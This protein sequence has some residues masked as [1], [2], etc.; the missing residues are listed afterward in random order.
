MLSK[1][2]QFTPF[3]Q[4]LSSLFSPPAPLSI[5]SI[6]STQTANQNTSGSLS[7]EKIMQ[8]S[9][10]PTPNK[11]ASIFSPEP[12][13]NLTNVLNDRQFNGGVAAP[14]SSE[15]KRKVESSGGYYKRM[16]SPSFG[17][18]KDKLSTGYPDKNMVSFMK[19]IILSNFLYLLDANHIPFLV[20]QWLPHELST[21][22]LSSHTRMPRESAHLITGSGRQRAR[23]NAAN[24]SMPYHAYS[25][26]DL[27]M[28][29][30]STIGA[31]NDFMSPMLQKPSFN[32]KQEP[33]H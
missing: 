5:N 8:S 29:H 16:G 12:K 18:P 19:K 17:A 13:M 4:T 33:E 26:Q 21:P 1:T 30:I 25:N 24:S 7:M 20:K 10:V 11:I 23:N 15:K 32:L 27:S 31:S 9:F 2:P 28:H 3:S 22:S 14:I 6:S